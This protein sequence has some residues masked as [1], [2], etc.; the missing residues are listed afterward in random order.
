M[1]I[2]KILILSSI[3]CLVSCA[4]P[5]TAPPTALGVDGQACMGNVIKPPAGLK[6]IQDDA[7]L[8]SVLAPTGKGMLCTGKVFSVEKPVIVYRVWDA[9]KAY[10]AYGR[11]WSLNLPKGPKPA[12]QKANDIC[13]SWS[14]LDRMSQCTLKV[15]AHVVIGPGQ[16]AQCEDGL[17]PASATN[18]VFVA[19]NSAA[20][21]VF[22]ENCTAGEVWPAQ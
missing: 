5:I 4:A 16:S 9:S 7:L 20:G 21:Q 22:V 1:N 8:N 13:P 6:E 10:T 11:W 18:Q 19:N 2:K 12:Y 15:G 3:L 17:Y 14:A